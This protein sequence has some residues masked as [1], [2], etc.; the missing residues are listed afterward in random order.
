MHS[1][2][3]FESWLC[4]A[5][6]AFQLPAAPPLCGACMVYNCKLTTVMP[7]CAGAVKA[8]EKHGGQD[9]NN[10]QAANCPRPRPAIPRLR[11]SALP[12]AQHVTQH[13]A[14]RKLSQGRWQ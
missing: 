5:D 8:Q 13:V 11:L 14:S 6:G 2:P 10:S 1:L 3:C 4:I 9:E 12:G 7:L